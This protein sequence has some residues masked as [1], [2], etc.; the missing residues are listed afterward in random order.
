[1]ENGFIPVKQPHAGDL[2]LGDCLVKEPSQQVGAHRTFRIQLVGIV[3]CGARRASQV[4]R[5][6]YLNI[7]KEFRLHD[8]SLESGGITDFGYRILT[9]TA[10]KHQWDMRRVE[11]DGHAA[12]TAL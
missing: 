12:K 1:M 10:A 8:A 9:P 11:M 6:K 3:S 4:A 7:K 2:T 5:P